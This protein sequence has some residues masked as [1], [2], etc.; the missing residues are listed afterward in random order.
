MSDAARRDAAALEC[1]HDF[2][3]RT[4]APRQDPADDEDVYRYLA[5]L[6]YAD[7]FFLARFMLSA[8]GN[9]EML[10]DEPIAAGLPERIHAPLD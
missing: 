1:R 9:I 6:Y 3:D 2:G 4:L 7:A 5:T 10:D 8:S